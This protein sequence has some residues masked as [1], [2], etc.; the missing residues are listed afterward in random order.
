MKL[1]SFQMAYIA[2][3]LHIRFLDLQP[4]N[5]KI[6]PAHVLAVLRLEILD[7]LLVEDVLMCD[8]FVT[9]IVRDSSRLCSTI[10]L[11]LHK[12]SFCGV[13]HGCVPQCASVRRCV[14]VCLCVCVCVFVCV[15]V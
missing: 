15:C 5:A 14:R 1:V 3:V 8:G 13:A 2:Y 9:S 10:D 12:D 4:W 6:R 11:G 7:E